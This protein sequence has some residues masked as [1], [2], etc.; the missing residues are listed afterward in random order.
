MTFHESDYAIR[1]SGVI[2]DESLQTDMTESTDDRDVL[3]SLALAGLRL[4]IDLQQ[5]KNSHRQIAP[6]RVKTVH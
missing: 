1:L 4:C 5:S 2:C 3:I 6:G